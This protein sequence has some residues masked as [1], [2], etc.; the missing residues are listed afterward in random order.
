MKDLIRIV[1]VDPNEES[2]GGLRQFLGTIDRIWIAEVLDAYAGAAPRVIGMAPDVI[3]VVLDPEPGQ[4]VDLVAT[5][6]RS[7]PGTAV[8]PA[9]WSSDGT[10]I[11]RAIR[12]GAREFLTLPTQPA[13]LLE[14]V[15]RLLRDRCRL[16]HGRPSD[17]RSSPSRVPRAA[18]V[19][20]PSRSNLAATLATSTNARRSS[21]ISISCSAPLTPR[22]TWSRTIRS[23]TCSR[24]RTTR[25]DPPQAVDDPARFRALRPASSDGDRGRRQD[26]PERLTGCSASSRP[27]S[28]PIVIDTSK[29][30]QASD[31]AA[32]EM[33]DVILI[34]VQLDSL[35]A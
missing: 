35:P 31:F 33:S 25:P 13:E 7:L 10:L 22:S 18:W 17:P 21:S 8:L 3:V 9:S 30:L 5:L 29:G 6:T 24:V 26:R 14:M 32:F 2:S 16:A 27:R 1:L 19:R 15:N 28:A 11:L 23:T 20:L 34:V 12:A 4:A